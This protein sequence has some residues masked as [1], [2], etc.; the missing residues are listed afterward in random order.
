MF[1]VPGSGALLTSFTPSH[2][3]NQNNVSN[4]SNALKGWHHPLENY[5]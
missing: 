3:D 4:I 2:A 5:W 1:S